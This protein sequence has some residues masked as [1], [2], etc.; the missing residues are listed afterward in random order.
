[1]CQSLSKIIAA[2]LYSLRGE[3]GKQEVLTFKNGWCV[4]KPHII[5]VPILRCDTGTPKLDCPWSRN[6]SH[7]ITGHAF[8][9]ANLAAV[10]ILS[11]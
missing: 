11:G 2:L 6:L 1:M 5:C 7:V 4:E 10:M 8:A 9:L 3:D